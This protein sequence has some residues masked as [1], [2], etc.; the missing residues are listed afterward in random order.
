MSDE[1]PADSGLIKTPTI[2]T[3]EQTQIILNRLREKGVGVLCT[4]CHGRRTVPV[5]GFFAPFLVQNSE[6]ALEIFGGKN[7]FP[8]FAMVCPNCGHTDFYS[9]GILGVMDM[10][11]KEDPETAPSK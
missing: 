10:F 3:E 6:K 2:I 7:M 5:D 9:L 11:A 4:A 8:L 1:S